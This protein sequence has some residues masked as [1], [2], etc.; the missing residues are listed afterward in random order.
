MLLSLVL[1]ACASKSVPADVETPS[2]DA[3]SGT[4]VP[5]A[6]PAPVSRKPIAL[7]AGKPVVRECFGGSGHG[8]AARQQPSKR[9]NTASTAAPAP[10]SAVAPGPPPPPNTPMSRPTGSSG[11]IA[12]NG[13]GA[14]SSA[15]KSAP[16]GGGG[17][18][19]SSGVG[20]EG[21]PVSVTAPKGKSPTSRAKPAAPMADAAPQD[22]GAA[23][24]YAVAEEAD[25]GGGTLEKKSARREDLARRATLPDKDDRGDADD[26]TASGRKSGFVMN[27][28]SEQEELRD[29]E[30]NFDWGGTT[31]LSND[32]SMSL[33]SA[34]RLLWAV[35]NR[36][37]VKT[38]EVRPHELLNYFSFDTSPVADG[39]VFSVSASAEQTGDRTLS[40]ALAIKGMTPQR[41]PL[42]MTLVL[43]RSGSMDAEGRMD[44]LKRGLTKMTD[45][46]ERGDRVDVVLFDDTVC[47]PLENYVVGRDDPALLADVIDDLQPRGSTDLNAGLREGY[48]VAKGH[49]DVDGRNRRML[50][51]SDALLNTGE[52]NTDV[53]SEIGKSY[54]SAGIRLS[55]VGVG[56][57]FNDKVLDQLSEKG[58]GAYVYLGSEAV[59]DR[60]FG[61]GFDSLVQTVAHDVHFSLDLPPSLAIEKFYGEESSTR[62]EDVQPINYYAGTTQL[63]VQDLRMSGARPARG[64]VVKVTAEWSDVDTGVA[65]T[66]TFTASVADLLDADPRNLHKGRALLAWSDMIMTRSLGGDPCGAPYSTWSERVD[67]LGEDAEVAWLD[68]LT[69]PLCGQRPTTPKTVAVRGV[70]YKVKVDADQVIAEVAME[71]GQKTAS[72]SL[73]RGSNVATFEV[74]PGS[75][76]LVL[77]GAVP[78]VASVQVPQAGGDV[79]CVVRGG[80][81]SCG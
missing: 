58:K 35:Q 68:S 57:D 48:R 71:C 49:E 5:E 19:D 42:D 47:S 59:V 65:R 60:I 51:I 25:E 46:L 15:D 78:M 81:L 66:Q 17:W 21:A 43:D 41:Q 22:A 79:R 31:Y 38:S 80:R 73:S 20:S 52:V 26:A 37:P 1:W 70:P 10:A 23:L 18:Y 67:A 50:L 34:Q 2:L 64:E 62:K 14:G 72:E 6:A 56:R 30:A 75:C 3:K 55:A 11:A 28:A 39:D 40:M 63:F 54:E 53:V 61:A 45:Q 69:S 13:K 12:S 32:D 33:A 74:R 16:T 24:G 4:M 7:L 29:R 36:G 77:Y 8:R 76:Q 44:Y 9:G 27:E